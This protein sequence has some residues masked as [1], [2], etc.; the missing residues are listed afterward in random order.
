MSV[1]LTR[2]SGKDHLERT[3]RAAGLRGLRASARAV[4]CRC[5]RADN[6]HVRVS[7]V[8][9]HTAGEPF[10]IVTDGAPRSPARPCASGGRR[11]PARR[12]WTPCA[13]CCATSRAGTPTCTAASWS[14]PTTTA[15]TSACCS[16]TRTATRRRAGTG[17]SRSARGRSS[18]AAC[19][20]RATA[21]S[22]SR[23]TCRRGA[24]SRACAGGRA[25]S[26]RSPS[27]TCRRSSL[28][29]GVPAAGRRGR[30]APT[31][32]RSTPPCRRRGSGCASCP[33]DLP[34]LIA[35]GREVKR[36]LAGTAAA[37]HPD[38]ERLS[39]IYGTILYDESARPAPA[40]RHGLRRRRGRPLTVRLGHL[41]ALRT[42]RG[43]R[44]ARRRRAA[45][46]RAASSAR[47]ST[48]A[49][50]G[51]TPEGVLTEV[52]GM[53]YRTGEHTFTLDPRD[54]LGTGFVLR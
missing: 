34:Q 28:A 11:P 16:G 53:A 2:V 37:R 30:R 36:A 49:S 29:R 12:R 40:Q 13:G 15:P 50:L 4:S 45:A 3:C 25:P 10:R 32:A 46:P 31:A 41:R 23:S 21:R 19:R 44:R 47:R 35:A 8:D 18:R 9:Y 27:A 52:E 17:R 42:A 6:P 20:R 7:T 24:S 38:D 43:R 48:R 51:T 14:S 22:T 39:G 1:L 26:R 33:S 54:P 5:R